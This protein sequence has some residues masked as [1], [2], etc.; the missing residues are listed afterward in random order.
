MN[1]KYNKIITIPCHADHELRNTT[2]S[3]SLLWHLKAQM[4]L[5]HLKIN[6]EITY[7]LK[8]I[9]NHIVGYYEKLLST[10]MVD[11]LDFNQVDYD[12]LDH[13]CEQW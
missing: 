6:G 4:P 8:I 1:K 13:F 3:H 12:Q 9:A 7:N 2:F 11:V 5:N 10:Q